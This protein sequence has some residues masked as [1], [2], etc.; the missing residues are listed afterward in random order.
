M[1]QITISEIKRNVIFTV[2]VFCREGTDTMLDSDSVG[3]IGNCGEIPLNN[4]D[5]TI[6]MEKS[7][8]KSVGSKSGSSLFE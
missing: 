8:M 2:G 6:G 4:A 7:G 1:L 3:N 5:S